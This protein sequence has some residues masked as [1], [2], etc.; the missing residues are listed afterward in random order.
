MGVVLGF[1]RCVCWAFLY[2]L[3][4][5]HLDAFGRK[6]WPPKQISFDSRC[7]SVS[8][9]KNV[10]VILPAVGQTGSTTLVDALRLMGM[11][12]YHDADVMLFAPTITMDGCSPETWHH[13]TNKCALDAVTLEPRSDAWWIAYAGSP[14]AKIIL[15][16]RDYPSWARST[17]SGGYVKDVRWGR[18]TNWMFQSL[19][20]FPW[21]Q[22]WD[23][24]TGQ[25]SEIYARGEV[26][27]GQTS[28]PTVLSLL[29]WYGVGRELYE[30]GNTRNRGVY[31]IRAQEEA[32][33]AQIEEIVKHVPATDL[34]YF[35]VR[36]HGY[37]E[38]NEFL[39]L[40]S[41]SLGTRLPH[42]RSKDSFSNDDK[43][44]AHPYTA[45]GAMA[46]STFLHVP[47]IVIIWLLLWPIRVLSWV[48]WRS[49]RRCLRRSMF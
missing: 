30:W 7:G 31:K 32:Y 40:P 38:L 33:V 2:Y 42:A 29:M 6:F 28:K 19:N 15:T 11:N 18:L 17:L 10:S 39:G 16:W 34:L 1:L 22:V 5:D 49:I 4:L 44:N 26:V 27:S 43:L 37:Q 12:A 9:K 21:F 20:V 23:L 47:N 48:Y 41:P 25:I 3:L 45:V 36:R 8:P 24:L 46:I 14:G 35:D 13:Y